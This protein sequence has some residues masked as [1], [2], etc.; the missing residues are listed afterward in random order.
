MMNPEVNFFFEESS[1]WKVEYNLLRNIVLEIGLQEELKWGVPCY[2]IKVNNKPTNVLLIHGFKTYCAVLFHKGALLKD[3]DGLLIQQTQNVQ[4]AR[5]VRFTS[6]NDI[7]QNT[8]S[9]RLLINQAITIEKQGLKVPL[10]ETE[11]YRVPEEF[12]AKLVSSPLLKIAFE[13]LTPGRQ[14]AYLLY[15]DQA[16]QSK[17]R[18]ARIEKCIP[19]ILNGKGLND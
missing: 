12:N 7:I 18:E 4:S 15:F 11:A 1:P 2:T 10:K 17:T 16:K 19:Q 13:S 3:P 5:Q 8:A 9:L 14:R 6:P